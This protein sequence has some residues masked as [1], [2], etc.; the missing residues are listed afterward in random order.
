MTILPKD[1]IMLL[2]VINT[3]LRDNYSNLNALCDAFEVSS[4]EIIK[5][6]DTID[7]HYDESLNQF[8]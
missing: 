8:K 4:D 2:S 1:P 3:N 7:Y 5:K 6:L